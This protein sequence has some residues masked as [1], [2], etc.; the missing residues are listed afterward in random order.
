MIDLCCH[1]LEG[2]EGGPESFRGSLEL[3]RQAVADGV[4]TVV[5]TPRWPSDS[6]A[7]PLAFAECEERL[8]R[9]RREM[10]DA[11]RL[12]LGFALQF[13]AGLPA[14]IEKYGSL[15]TLGGVGSHVL[16]A[17]PSLDVPT[18]AEEVWAAVRRLGFTPVIA[19]PECS[20]GLRREPKRLDR[21]V[22]AGAVV[23]LD[24]ASVTGAHGREVWRFAGRCVE[25]YGAGSVVIASNARESWAGRRPSL[26]QAAEE[27]ARKIGTRRALALVEKTP[28][29]IIGE[30][31]PTAHKRPRV[32]LSRTFWAN[33]LRS[34]LAPKTLPE[35]S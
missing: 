8:A 13:G 1:L 19:R 24:A 9:L 29:Q 31:G 35:E 25:R 20:L 15:I 22:E 7:P 34:L 6:V 32:N 3:C 14:L 2:A 5:A 27:A 26:R 21:W 18:E 4:L 16:V 12:K 30:A 10:G 17:L 23:Q 33:T 11:L 28:A